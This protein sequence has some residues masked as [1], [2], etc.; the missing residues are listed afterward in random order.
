MAEIDCDHHLASFVA[1]FVVPPRR[2]RWRH[3]LLSR[4][5][6]AFSTSHKLYD[7]LDRSVCTKLS[8]DPPVADSQ[9]G[10]YYDFY[11]EPEV[12]RFGDIYERSLGTDAIFSATPGKLA[13][14]FFHEGELWLCRK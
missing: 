9:V 2:E 8:G 14:F 7:A 13:V 4:G 1:S 6:K 10:V 11:E 12:A 5:K 3:L